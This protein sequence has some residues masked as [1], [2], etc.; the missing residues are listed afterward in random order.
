VTFSFPLRHSVIVRFFL[1][2]FNGT[3]RTQIQDTITATVRDKLCVS[4]ELFRCV[5]TVH[6]CE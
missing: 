2:L 4:F 3:I 6:S 1:Y 5:V